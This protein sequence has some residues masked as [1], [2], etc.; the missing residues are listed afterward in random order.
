MSTRSIIPIKLSLTQ[1]DYYTLWAPAWKEKGSEWQAFLGDE[2]GI[3]VFAS[4]EELLLFLESDA[5]HDLTEHPRWREFEELGA[6][7]VSPDEEH[8]YDIVG[9]PRY[10]AERPTTQSVRGLAAVLRVTKP[11]AEVGSLE[12]VQ[13]FFSSHSVLGNVQRGLEHFTDEAGKSEWAGIGHV[14]LENWEKVVTALDE[15]LQHPEVSHEGL[16]DA[17]KRIASAREELD[18]KRA[19]EEKR[20]ERERAQA[21]PYD[22]TPWAAAGIDPISISID[23]STLYTL[24]TY[25]DGKAVFLGRYREIFTFNNRRALVRWM[26]AGHEHDL[27]GLST[28]PDLETAANAGELEVTVHKDNAYSFKGIAHDIEKGVDAVDT[29]QMAQCYELLADA[30]DWAEDDSINSFF[31]AHPRMQDYISYMIGSGNT[32]GYVPSAPFTDHS[33]AWRELEDMLRKRFSRS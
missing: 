31:L 14:V 1:G 21:D 5:P 20:R 13:V 4:P 30:A 7:R 2:T 10:L 15:G 25:V 26:V 32:S 9:A 12:R 19:E 17:K 16:N 27:Q 6:A 18:A 29:A 33:N 3:F 11:L 28:W 22:S 23:G 24:R 8:E